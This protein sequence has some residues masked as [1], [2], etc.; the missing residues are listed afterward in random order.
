M[1][2]AVRDG[3][4][5]WFEEVTILS[6]YSCN[7]QCL[8]CEV[9]S[10][11]SLDDQWSTEDR[12]S[13]ID[14]LKDFSQRSGIEF[15]GFAVMG[16][17]PFLDPAFI[18]IC[19]R[20]NH[21]FPNAGITVYTNGLLMMQ[22]K[23]WLDTLCDITQIR[24]YITIHRDDPKTIK[25]ITSAI[26][27]L[28]SKGKH[29]VVKGLPVAGFTTDEVK[30]FWKMPFIFNSTG[31]KLYPFEHNDPLMSWATCSVK[32]QTHLIDHNLYKCTKLAYL[33]NGLSKTKQLDDPAWQRYLDY[34]PLDL[35]TADLRAM[36]EFASKTV[37]KY[38]AMCPADNK[39]IPNDK[40]IYRKEYADW[41]STNGVVKSL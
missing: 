5:V 13:W 38:C 26:I 7:L 24:F 2:H 27:Y 36:S 17:E 21:H 25:N 10:N 22:R 1:L 34:E 16:G 12:L 15:N 8:G 29:P 20:I 3:K 33:K 37:E 9:H 28:R 4:M 31:D 23:E 18:D 39:Y 40:P 32:Y 14:T 11:M 30:G 41:L 35:R 19:K 6:T